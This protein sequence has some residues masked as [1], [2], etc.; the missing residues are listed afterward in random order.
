[1]P[2]A[3]KY[4]KAGAVLQMS[5]KL[6]SIGD[7]STGKT[8]L[9]ARFGQN[10]F[11]EH[12]SSTIGVEF[13][14]VE[15]SGVKMTLWDTAGQ[16]RYRTLTSSYYRGADIV[17]IVYAVSDRDS[18]QNLDSWLQELS[19]Y[20]D[21]STLRVLVGNKTDVEPRTVGFEEAQAFAH[22]HGLSFA[23]VSVRLGT[24]VFE[25]LDWMVGQI[26]TRPPVHRPTPQVTTDPDT[27]RDSCCAY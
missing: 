23:E 11:D 21:T 25:L 26:R 10:T 15:H 4:L 17:L 19:A 9:L 16:E 6:V 22:R 24:G 27:R 2:Y 8:S 1:M 12:Q 3:C 20:G 7:A 14:T 13:S 5:Y 18:F